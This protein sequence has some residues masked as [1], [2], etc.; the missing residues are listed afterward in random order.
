MPARLACLRA[1]RKRG[2]NIS[3]LVLNISLCHGYRVIFSVQPYKKERR[4]HNPSL[5][6][7]RQSCSPLYGREQGQAAQHPV[8]PATSDS[9]NQ[10]LTFL[11][12]F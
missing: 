2:I 8:I 7:L 10:N 9:A 4:L 12:H 5:G 1:G 6:R 11:S 3:I